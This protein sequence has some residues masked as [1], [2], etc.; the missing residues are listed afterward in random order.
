[1]NYAAE[2]IQ[3]EGAAYGLS[4]PALQ[5]HV[6]RT[7]DENFAYVVQNR[8]R[9]ASSFATSRGTWLGR[10]GPQQQQASGRSG[11]SFRPTSTPGSKSSVP[12]PRSPLPVALPLALARHLRRNCSR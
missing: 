4:G 10:Q 11:A 6:T 8:F 2:R 7:L 3:A 1:M 9:S 12:R 5:E